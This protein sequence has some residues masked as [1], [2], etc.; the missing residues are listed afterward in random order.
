[1][2]Q[3]RILVTGASGCIGHYISET[4]IQNTNHELFLLVRNPN[5]LQVDIQARPG[6]TVLQGDMQKISHFADL[7]Q[8]IDIAVLT[9]TAWGG[10]ETF[11]INVVKT[12]E[13]L[14]LLDPDRCEQVIYFSTA[15]VLDRHN[16][17]LKEAGEIGTDYI[18]SKYECLHQKSKLAIASKITAVFPTLVLGGDANKPYSHATSGIP[19]ITKY[20][21]LIRFLKVDGSFHFIHGRDVATVVQYLIDHPPQTNEPRQFVLGQAPLTANQAVKELCAYLG[22]K[23]Y[24]RIPLS[25]GLANLIIAVFRIQMA[26]WDRFC[27]SDRHFTYE[28]AINPD[29][30]NL[31]NYCATMSDVLKI[32]GIKSAK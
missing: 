28:K 11:D 19:E 31:P 22:K 1:M 26:A 12:I 18:R 32:S 9:A 14:K 17:P 13:L 5:K 7:L 15:S 4:L 27:M 2:S 30:F 21:N 8:T 29:S 16:Q 6:I 24:F 20:V 10:D 3:K 23:I 25:L